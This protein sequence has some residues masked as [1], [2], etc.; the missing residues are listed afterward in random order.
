MKLRTLNY[1]I[2]LLMILMAGCSQK[3]TA[4]LF[5][6]LTHEQTGIHFSNKV[7]PTPSFN[8]FSYMYFYN[9]AGVGAGDFNND[10]LIDLFFAANQQPNALY[11]NTGKLN[12]K[13]VTAMVF[14]R[15]ALHH[16][17][18]LRSVEGRHKPVSTMGL[19][20]RHWSACRGRPYRPS[21]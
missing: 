16:R 6:P 19:Y 15:R 21:R 5:V 9:G 14:R 12:F 2:G 11:L 17:N 20:P 3:K 1:S 10:G 13:D 18:Q 7:Q 8:L 4:S